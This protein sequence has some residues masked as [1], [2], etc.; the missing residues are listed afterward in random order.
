VIAKRYA[1]GGSF[2]P[3]AKSAA[4]ARWKDDLYRLRNQIVHTGLREVSFD[5]A[6]RGLIAGLHAVDA[7]NDLA[8]VF[9]RSMRWSGDALDLPHIQQS[10]GRL[11][12]L[13]ES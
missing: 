12:R 8:P 1:T 13:F 10:A 4:Y 6:K 9:A 11:S 7:I 3:F 2:T 5:L